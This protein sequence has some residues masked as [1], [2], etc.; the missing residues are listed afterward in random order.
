MFCPNC[1]TQMTNGAKFCKE[2][3]WHRSEIN[4]KKGINFNMPIISITSIIKG[5]IIILI[6]GIVVNFIIGKVNYKKTKDIYRTGIETTA[7]GK[8]VYNKGNNIY[9]KNEIVKEGSNLYYF[10]SNEEMV[11]NDWVEYDG[12]WYYCESDGKI[13]KSKWVENTY[14]VNENGQ[15]LKNTFTP[16]GYYVGDDGKYVDLNLNNINAQ[17]N[18]NSLSEQIKNAKSYE[19]AAVD[20][21]VTQLKDVIN[22]Q[23]TYIDIANK[24]VAWELNKDPYYSKDEIIEYWKEYFYGKVLDVIL[25][26]RLNGTPIKINERDYYVLFWF[27]SRICYPLIISIQEDGGNIITIKLR[28]IGKN[29]VIS[30]EQVKESIEDSINSKN[31][32]ANNKYYESLDSEFLE[33]ILEKAERIKNLQK[34]ILELSDND[35]QTIIKSGVYCDWWD[36]KIEQVGNVH[37]YQK[38]YF[39]EISLQFIYDENSKCWKWIPNSVSNIGRLLGQI[40]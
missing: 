10:N 9:A 11:K 26:P 34:L 21:F 32:S 31:H 37:S 15:M 5:I 16:D 8:I 4:N 19:N 14:Y 36:R 22:E 1:G 7:S 29:D 6:I 20:S 13:A 12:K 39:D 33:Y 40:Q 2:C 38:D 24:Y 18:S 30:E 3:G 17:V 28:D 25:S 23:P 35:F 27:E